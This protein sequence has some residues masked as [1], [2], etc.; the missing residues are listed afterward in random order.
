ML[1][2]ESTTINGDGKFDRD[3][4]YV[5]DVARANVLLLQHDLAVPFDAFNVGTAIATDVNVL[6]AELQ[7]ACQSL[8]HR[9]GSSVT[10]PDPTHGPDRPGDLRSSIVSFDKIKASL[11][12]KPEVSIREGLADTAAWFCEH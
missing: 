9:S 4:V 12:W 5:T 10:I 6:A 8:I 1:R 11:G 7:R 3:Y 2:G